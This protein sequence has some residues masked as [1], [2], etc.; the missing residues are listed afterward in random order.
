LPSR[1]PS[2]TLGRTLTPKPCFLIIFRLKHY[3]LIFQVLLQ[4]CN[5]SL[6]DDEQNQY[7]IDD[8]NEDKEA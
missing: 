2:M 6:I 3:P 7:D 5:A 4:R 8:M 1:S